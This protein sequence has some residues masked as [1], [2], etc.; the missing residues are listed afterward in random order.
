M[1]HERDTPLALTIGE[2]LWDLLPSGKLLGGAPANCCF[3]LRQLGV[4]AKMVSRIGSDPLGAEIAGALASKGFDLSLVQRDPSLPTGTV[5]VQLGSDGS[6]EFNIVKGV[7]YDALEAAPDALEAAARAAVICFGTL[8]QRSPASRATICRLLDS[9]PRAVRFLDINL[10]KDC[11]SAETVASSLERATIIKLN[12]GEVAEVAR[13]LGLTAQGER[14]RVL[15]LMLRFGTDTVLV[16]RGDRG[17]FAVGKGGEEVDLPGIQVKVVDTIGSGDACSAGFIAKLLEGAP[18]RECAHF[19]NIMGA[20]NAT[21]AG[22]MPDLSLEEVKEFASR[23]P[24]PPA[25]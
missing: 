22:G 4:N 15:E 6:P 20:L 14:E 8:A 5:V 19:G 10:R 11:Y 23:H 12:S 18:L 25:P 17:V 3:R 9:S 16:T 24:L 1:A 21:R 7:A 2:I 13:L